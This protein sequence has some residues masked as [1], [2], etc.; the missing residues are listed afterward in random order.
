[1]RE[2]KRLASPLT[3]RNTT[4]AKS[5]ASISLLTAPPNTDIIPVP[6]TIGA[7]FCVWTKP[8]SQATQALPSKPHNWKID[9]TIMPRHWR[10]RTTSSASAILPTWTFTFWSACLHDY[11]WKTQIE[12]TSEQRNPAIGGTKIITSEWLQYISNCILLYNWSGKVICSSR[13][14][15]NPVFDPENDQLNIIQFYSRKFNCRYMLVCLCS[16]SECGVPSITANEKLRQ[17][18]KLTV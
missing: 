14:Y 11:S 7:T 4:L 5:V 10:D 8:S 9:S 6:T 18:D 2:Q 17:M 16:A 12:S 13:R 3:C 15:W 1:M